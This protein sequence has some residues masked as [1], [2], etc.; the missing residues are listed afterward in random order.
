VKVLLWR[1]RF[2]SSSLISCKLQR[3]ILIEE[4]ECL[5]SIKIVCVFRNTCFAN[6]QLFLIT[7]LVVS[8]LYANL[9]DPS[10]MR[11]VTRS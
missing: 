3:R 10:S 6:L 5:E 11:S 9:L 8:L 7:T 1:F 4:F 2:F